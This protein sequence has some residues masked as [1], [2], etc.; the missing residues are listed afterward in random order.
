VF[1]TALAFLAIPGEMPE[2]PQ[3]NGL[4]LQTALSGFSRDLQT[5]DQ[6][7]FF[8]KWAQASVVQRSKNLPPLLPRTLPGS[9]ADVIS[10]ARPVI[11]V[12]VQ[13]WGERGAKAR[14]A[15]SRDMIFMSVRPERFDRLGR[16]I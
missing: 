5:F 13:P 3:N 8:G 7:L 12:V 15:A 6:Q 10:I 2:A 16:A 9:F 14:N 4:D 11:S 1:G